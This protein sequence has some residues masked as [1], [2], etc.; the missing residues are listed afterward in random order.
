MRGS[1][2]SPGVLHCLVGELNSTSMEF[3]LTDDLGSVRAAITN[4]AGTATVVGYMGYGPFGFVQY[5]A[6]QT[7][8]NKGYT[9]QYN[10][11]LSGLDYYVARYYDPVVG[12]FLSADTVQSNLQGFDPYAYVGNNPETKNDPT[13]LFGVLF[14]IATGLAAVGLA[15]A[16]TAMFVPMA[17][18]IVGLAAG[19]AVGYALS[20]GLDY[21]QNGFQLPTTDRQWNQWGQDAL[22]AEVEDGI[23][24]AVGAWDGAPA[25]SPQYASMGA[26]YAANAA[27][28]GY[29]FTTVVKSSI[30]VGA[31]LAGLGGVAA[32]T[33]PVVQSS[34]NTPSTKP[35]VTPTPTATPT[36]NTSNKTV[37]YTT[38]APPPDVSK[39]AQPSTMYYM[40]TSGDTL[41]SIAA[42][43]YGSGLQ[44]QRIYQANMGVIGVNPNLIFSGERLVIPR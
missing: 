35:K 34:S 25:P 1:S 12:L 43:F 36:T 22:F 32:L 31:T 3:V 17:P 7:G 28:T 5:H 38:S 24:G 2:V 8:T 11:P 14:G 16:L 21:I 4:Q 9:G 23:A 41:W 20:V 19:V 30:T 37:A 15:V 27:K 42:R 26:E 39:Q 13:G 29:A 6:G 33:N 44:W 10:D 18:V 40:V